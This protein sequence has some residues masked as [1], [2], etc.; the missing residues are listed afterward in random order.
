MRRPLAALALALA[1][2][3]PA[4]AQDFAA[5]ARAEVAALV[6]E[7]HGA[8]TDPALSDAARDAA[9]REAAADAFALDLW[10]RAVLG[11]RAERFSPEQRAAFDALLPGYLGGL[12]VENFAGAGRKPEVGGARMARRDALVAVTMF[13]ARGEPLPLDYRVRDRAGGPAVLD[14]IIGG[15]SFAILRRE[16]FGALIDREGPDALIAFMRD[17]AI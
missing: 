14:V 16:E 1:A 5:E 8:L 6:D 15:V 12:Y 2:S 7:M 10:G 3:A 17:K 4:P 9:I 11:D 13:R